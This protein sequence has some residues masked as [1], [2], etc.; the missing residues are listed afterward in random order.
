MVSFKYPIWSFYF[1]KKTTKIC[2]ICELEFSIID[3]L[4]RC[5]TGKVYCSSR[6]KNYQHNVLDKGKKCKDCNKPI[7]Q[8]A[9]HCGSCMYKYRDFKGEK[10]PQYNGGNGAGYIQ[11]IARESVTASGRRINKCETCGKE[12]NPGWFM[13]IHHINGDRKNNHYS[14]LQVLCTSCHL[15]IHRNSNKIVVK[16]I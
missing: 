10:N 15:K 9:T 14:N 3:R 12:R 1:M 5:I 16:T 2:P 11:R 4:N 13:I 8:S 6:C 7:V